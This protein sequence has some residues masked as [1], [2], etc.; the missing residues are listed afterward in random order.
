MKTSNKILLALLAVVFAVPFALAVSLKGKISS[1]QYVSKK[2]NNVSDNLRSGAI[3]SA[4]AVKVVAPRPDL[5]RCHLKI[6]D[7]LDYTFYK[8]SAG[9]SISVYNANDTLFVTYISA[10]T[11]ANGQSFDV[12]VNLPAFNSIVA[13]GAVV[14]IDSVSESLSN[15]SI[16]LKNNG[17]IK[18]G[19]N[20]KKEQSQ[21]A[22]EIQQEQLQPV[23]QKKKH[24][25]SHLIN[26]IKKTKII[27][28][29][30]P[31]ID[32]ASILIERFL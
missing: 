3:V 2:F 22:A 31:P 7:K 32:V 19:G 28:V 18:D 14:I 24:N 30:T 4:K 23:S 27:E 12:N 29:S 6:S 21:P 26:G 5:L 11:N 1:N 15:L 8:G 20:Y 17:E 9:D 13:D 25:N 16:T 10:N